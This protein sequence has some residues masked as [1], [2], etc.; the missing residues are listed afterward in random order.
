MGLWFVVRNGIGY[1]YVVVVDI[2]EQDIREKFK[3]MVIDICIVLI[4]II[5]F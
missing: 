3:C 4:I 1:I 2:V 5:K